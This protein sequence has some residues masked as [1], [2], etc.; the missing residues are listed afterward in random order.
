MRCAIV[1]RTAAVAPDGAE[2]DWADAKPATADRL[3]AKRRLKTSF[4]FIE[5]QASEWLGIESA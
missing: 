4:V 1:S 3:A 2:V 5:G